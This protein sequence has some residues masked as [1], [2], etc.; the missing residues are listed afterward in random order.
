MSGQHSRLCLFFYFIFEKKYVK[1][2]LIIKGE[3]GKN[4]E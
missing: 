2:V 3:V 1:I 4:R